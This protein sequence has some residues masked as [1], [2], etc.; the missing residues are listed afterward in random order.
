MERRA[1]ALDLLVHHR[2]LIVRTKQTLHSLH[3]AARFLYRLRNGPEQAALR[4][5]AIDQQ[6][7]EDLEVV[8]AI[9]LRAQERCTLL[10]R[11]A[12]QCILVSGVR[13][14][15]VVAFEEDLVNPAPVI[16]RSKGRFETFHCIVAPGMI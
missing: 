6:N 14:L 9:G 2:A 8:K 7:P 15:W 3:A 16:E 5:F 10:D 1:I 4:I 13:N 11:L 12:S